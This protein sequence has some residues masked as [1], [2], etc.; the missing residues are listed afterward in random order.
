[1]KLLVLH[2]QAQMSHLTATDFIEVSTFF[3]HDWQRNGCSVLLTE[4]VREENHKNT[5]NNDAM[6]TDEKNCIRMAAWCVCVCV[7]VW[8][9]L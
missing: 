5:I 8:A 9:T 6:E 4:N 7:C 1:M 2:K 3:C